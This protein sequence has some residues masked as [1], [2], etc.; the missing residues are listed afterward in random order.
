MTPDRY[1][2]GLET[3]DGWSDWPF[4]DV[5]RQGDKF[6]WNHC[7]NKGEVGPTHGPFNTA[8]EAYDDANQT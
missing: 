7:D 3:T 5:W 2:L 4:F 1:W 8:K 6:Y